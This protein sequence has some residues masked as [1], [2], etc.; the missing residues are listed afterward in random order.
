MSRDDHLALAWMA[1][2]FGR[3][4]YLPLSGEDLAALS[5]ATTPVEF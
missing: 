4:D 5:E 3:R 2:Y 1:R